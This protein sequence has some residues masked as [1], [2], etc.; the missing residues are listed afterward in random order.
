MGVGLGERV[1][2]IAM[3][4]VG[5]GVDGAVWGG[6]VMLA[7]YTGFERVGHLA[8]QPMPGGDAATRYPV[9]MLIGILSSFLSEEETIELLRSVGALRGLRWGEEEA[10]LAY[11]MAKKRSPI[12]SS[13]GRVLD[14][15]SA[16]LGVCYERTYEG[17]P[18]M[19]LEAFG[20]RGKLVEGIEAPLRRS[21]G[22]LV[23]DT[24]SLL[25]SVVNVLGEADPRDIAYTVMYRVGE[26]LG[27]IAISALNR[28]TINDALYVSGGA[29]VNDIIVAGIENTANTENVKVFLPRRVPA[30]D[31]GIA[32]GQVAIVGA[33]LLEE[34]V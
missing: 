22:V 6:E 24:T 27:R 11:R 7:G 13:T 2:G 17:E 21:N 1:V 5:Y 15:V 33:K 28:A 18:A 4:G 30:G 3:D 10:K 31:G 25:E 12:T 8:Y 23:V 19:K 20:R 9:R 16:L 29:A 14:A 34:R 26:A 32:L